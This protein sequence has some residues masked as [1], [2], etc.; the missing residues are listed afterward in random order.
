MIYVGDGIN[1]SRGRAPLGCASTGRVGR[2]QDENCESDSFELAAHQTSPP[3]SIDT[4]VID[5]HAAGNGRYRAAA[6][7]PPHDGQ[8]RF[9]P[10]AHPLSEESGGACCDG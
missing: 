6:A 4:I 1:R 10:C 9:G 2:K 7:T 8:T 5:L 3:F